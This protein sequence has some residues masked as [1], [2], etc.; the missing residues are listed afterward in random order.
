ML[1]AAGVLVLLVI[2]RQTTASRAGVA[3]M[4][5]QQR[6]LEDTVRLRTRELAEASRRLAALALQDGLT[7]LPN[8]RAF[9]AAL[10]RC[11]ADAGRAGAPLSLLL[12]DVDAFKRFNDVA[13]HQA[14]DACLQAVASCLAGAVPRA[15]DTVARYGGEEFA[16]LAP[17][18]GA[19]G[20]RQL[21]DRVLQ[22]VRAAKLEHPASPVGPNVTVSVGAA[23]MRPER[24]LSSSDLVQ[25]ADAA[26]YLA[27]QAGRDCAEM[28]RVPAGISA[29]SR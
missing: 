7:G 1:M 26:L 20:A 8:R 23:S 18:T 13:G 3:W 5:A 29:P 14:G 9:D 19:D 28:A 2:V 25:A 10:E 6:M 11:W 4:A 16:V 15:T 24:H 17:H 27:K 12:I 21:A 22:A